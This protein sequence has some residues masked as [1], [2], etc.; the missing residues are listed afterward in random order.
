MRGSGN[1]QIRGLGP[2]SSLVAESKVRRK[3][4]AL[5]GL[6]ESDGERQIVRATDSESE[7]Q[8]VRKS[9]R[10]REGRREGRRGGGRE[11]GEAGTPAETN[12]RPHRWQPSWQT[13][14]ASKASKGTEREGARESGERDTH[15]TQCVTGLKSAQRISRQSQ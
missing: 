14:K 10:M 12:R 8:R 3:H 15:L 4:C 9:R 13:D 1:R 6:C 7:G 5:Q 2:A 11:K